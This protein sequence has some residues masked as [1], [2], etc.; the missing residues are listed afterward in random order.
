MC[1]SNFQVQPYKLRA[2]R[3]IKVGMVFI[4]KV[5][6]LLVCLVKVFMHSPTMVFGRSP[7]LIGKLTLVT[8][9]TISSF[10]F[11]HG[12]H[13]FNKLLSDNSALLCSRVIV[14]SAAARIY[15]YT[16]LYFMT[17]LICV[18]RKSTFE[19]RLMN[20]DPRV[21]VQK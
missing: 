4:Q 9:L 6:V 1:V 10:S 16:Q 8:L 7:S 13:P 20:C 14:K 3:E 12:L 5:N 18:T 19:L 2:K 15:F 21:A 17:N 11:K